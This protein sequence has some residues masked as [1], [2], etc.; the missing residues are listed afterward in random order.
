M[1]APRTYGDGVLPDGWRMVRLGDVANVNFSGVDKKL[2]AGEIPVRL[3]NYTDVFYNRRI[4]PDMEFMIA[5]ASEAECKR[6]HLRQGDVLFTKDS[7]TPDEIGI[8]S[9]VTEGMPDVLCGYHLGMARPIND[10]VDGLFLAMTLNS[11]TCRR[12]FTRVANG[13]TR[14]GL[15][16]EPTRSIPLFLPPLH[17]QR[18]IAAV[19]DSTDEAIER[20]ET[21]IAAINTLR[22]ALIRE[23]LTRGVP[24]WHT[25]WKDIPGI[26]TIPVDWEVVRLGDVL[27]ST[28]YGTN[29]PL[30]DQG[31][32]PVLRMNNL[33]G[34]EVDWSEVRRADL[35]GKEKRELDVQAG[36]ILFN[37]T[38]SLD[39]VG[40]VAI[41]RCLPEPT[42]FASYLIRLRVEANRVDPVWLSY[43]LRSGSCQSR[44]RRFATP[45]VSQANVNPTSLK[46]MG[47]PVPS[48][49]EQAVMVELLDSVRE[50]AAREHA[51]RD[52][53][54]SAKCSL[55]DALLTGR[56]RI[57]S[58]QRARTG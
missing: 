54:E 46:S 55:A 15:T 51:K 32:S 11:A 26:G 29:D 17:E 12:Q 42:S 38:N 50:Q 16:L 45:G 37:R 6:W 53:L 33:Q 48:L 10:V 52:A 14:F 28:T 9:A 43:L 36:D 34:G 19:L 1:S 39:L 4:T 8:A 21:I 57:H 44:I 27:E 13:V 35:S 41:V 3:C 47:I 49:R 56:T 22:D 18:S 31:S 5:T 20:T 2:V 40:K 30:G 7:E 58:L 25:A 24:G 23:L